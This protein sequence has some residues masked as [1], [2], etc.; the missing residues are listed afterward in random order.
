[1]LTDAVSRFR[2]LSHSC[3]VSAPVSPRRMD[4]FEAALN[5]IKL[6]VLPGATFL[7]A[8][9]SGS[10]T[11]AAYTAAAR[12]S[13]RSVVKRP[14]WP[15][16]TFIAPDATTATGRIVTFAVSGIKVRVWR[17]H[18]TFPAL[19][20]VRFRDTAWVG[21]VTGKGAHSGRS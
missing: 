19:C 18:A 21:S 5:T 11:G 9:T 14:R 16:E 1:M 20:L 12:G 10:W 7:D 4:R 3:D 8:N 17:K 6:V 2:P 13:D 15:I